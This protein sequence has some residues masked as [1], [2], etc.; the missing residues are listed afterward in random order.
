MNSGPIGS[1]HKLDMEYEVKYSQTKQI[2]NNESGDNNNYG[3]RNSVGLNNHHLAYSSK[4]P[5]SNYF[6]NKRAG[7]VDKPPM[8]KK[9]SH[10]SK[11]SSTLR[12]NKYKSLEKDNKDIFIRPTYGSAEE[13][14]N[15]EIKA[16][17]MMKVRKK[18][19]ENGENAYMSKRLK[20]QPI[21]NSSSSSLRYKKS[22]P[23]DML[24]EHERH[25][26][27]VKGNMEAP[28]MIIK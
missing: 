16:N 23:L 21:L 7:I 22:T 26:P 24:H 6:V 19:L 25:L 28:N 18:K 12:S 5:D 3:K 11:S 17:G 8:I 2:E 10:S 27:E 14:K 15:Y 9:R 20:N 4:E 1:C 13:D